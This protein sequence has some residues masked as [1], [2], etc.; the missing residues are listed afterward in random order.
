LRKQVHT[1]E[2]RTKLLSHQLE[3]AQAEIKD[4]ERELIGT[5]GDCKKIY[6]D[7]SNEC[8]SDAD[9]DKVNAISKGGQDALSELKK[10]DGMLAV[11]LRA[12]LDALRK[13][14]DGLKS[15]F[16]AK[17]EQLVSALIDKEQLRKEAE[18]TNTELQKAVE[19]QAVNADV[20]KTTEKMEK[21]RARYKK[22]SEVSVAFPISFTVWE[23]SSE[24]Q[25]TLGTCGLTYFK[26]AIR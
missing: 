20:I 23:W 6:I 8:Y 1:E 26:T 15:G 22:L 13:R 25:N 16:D 19:G 18:V 24:G 3:T 14:Y 7:Q 4:K 17:Q 21:L 10:T 2:S 12:E 5:R 11:S 9:D